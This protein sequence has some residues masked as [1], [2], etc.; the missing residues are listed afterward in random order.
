[1]RLLLILSF[2]LTACSYESEVWKSEEGSVVTITNRQIH[3][4]MS[5]S[6]EFGNDMF[7]DF[8]GTI[9]EVLKGEPASDHQ[10]IYVIRNKDGFVS[11]LPII[12]VND[13]YCYFF[14]HTYARNE[15]YYR[16]LKEMKDTM[17]ANAPS[18]A[19]LDLLKQSWYD[20]IFEDY[21]YLSDE[22]F[23]FKKQ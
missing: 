6:D 8:D 4:K 11:M 5:D 2:F 9:D 16:S 10:Y 12:E 19:A 17:I 21:L 14:L 7:S 18:W 22:R 15:G 13:Q 23:L 1:M 3:I 20:L